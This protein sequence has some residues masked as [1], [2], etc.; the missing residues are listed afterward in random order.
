[1]GESDA[2]VKLYPEGE[3]FVLTAYGGAVPSLPTG[4]HLHSEGVRAFWVTGVSDLGSPSHSKTL[5]SV[6]LTAEPGTVC[7]MRYGYETRRDVVEHELRGGRPFSFE[8]LSFREFSFDTG[9]ARADTRRV[10]ERGFNY[11]AFRISSD[12]DT[13]CAPA[14]LSVIYQINGYQGGLR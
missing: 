7:D 3:P 6:S 2:R 13:D 9:F 8:G 4:R 12:G 14:R 10:F 5:L 11:I 1:M